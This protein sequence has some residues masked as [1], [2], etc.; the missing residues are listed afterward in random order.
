MVFAWL[1]TSS[2]N[3]FKQRDRKVIDNVTSRRRHLRRGHLMDARAHRGNQLIT[4]WC[5]CMRINM[6]VHYRP[7]MLSWTEIRRL[8][9]PWNDAETETS[10]SRSGSDMRSGIVL[11]KDVVGWT[12]GGSGGG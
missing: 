5:E 7:D 1:A 10:E 11:L 4:R 8:R 9:W 12:D 3:A 6:L 2:R